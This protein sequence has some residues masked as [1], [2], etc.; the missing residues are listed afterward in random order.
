MPAN[1][2][3]KMQIARKV[4][5][6]KTAKNAMFFFNNDKPACLT[7]RFDIREGG[8]K[9]WQ[10]DFAS[11]AGKT[12]EIAG[13]DFKYEYGYLELGQLISNHINTEKVELEKYYKLTLL[14]DK[15]LK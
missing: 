5:A 2:N 9:F 10:E 12:K 11:I 8:R 4:Y 3:L 15:N 7:K 6:I 1:E 14:T 13:E